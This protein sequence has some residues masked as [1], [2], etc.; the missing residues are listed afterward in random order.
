MDARGV[1]LQSS[2]TQN[3][4]ESSLTWMLEEW[5]YNPGTH[6]MAGESSLTWMHGE[7]L[8]NPGRHRMA[9]RVL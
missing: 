2:Y 6:R 5:L 8:Y 9:G 3:G 7:W 1:A 4:W